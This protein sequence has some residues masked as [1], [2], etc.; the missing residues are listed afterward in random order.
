MQP[1]RT[2]GESSFCPVRVLFLGDAPGMG[3][4]LPAILKFL[5]PRV[6]HRTVV[7]PRRGQ[8]SERLERS[9]AADE[10]II[11]PNL[12]ENPVEPWRRAMSADDLAAPCGRKCVRFVGN[13]ARAA[14]GFTR[15]SRLAKRGGYDLI[16]CNGTSADLAGGI[17]S[18]A[19]SVPALWHVRYTSIPDLVAPIHR[20]LSASAGVRRIVC[21]S[22]AA[23]GLFSHCGEKIRVVQG[24]IDTEEDAR[25]EAH[26]IQSEIVGVVGEPQP[27]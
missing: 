22:R 9:R 3:R 11:E 7:L 5:D 10:V 4:A 15:L 26:E 12:V 2:F 23:A 25:R 27:C 18:A 21:V 8:A 6:I 16:Y 14:A 24:A 19:T 1:S 13:V 20:L 17:L